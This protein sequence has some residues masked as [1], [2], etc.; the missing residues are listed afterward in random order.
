MRYDTTKQL[1][2]PVL[3]LAFN[4]PKKTK[5][6]FDSIRSVKPV[7]LYVAVDGPR[8]GREDDIINSNQVKEIVKDVDWSCDVHYL[9]HD[10]NLGCS[11]SGYMAWKWIMETEDRMI[12][13][14][15]DGLGS[16]EAF[17]FI[18]DMLERYNDDERVS[19]V[20]AVNYGPK[21]GEASYFYSRIP[22]ATYFM[23]TWKR[24]MDRYEYLLD[25]FPIIRK[26]PD[27]RSAF[28]CW[29]ERLVFMQQFKSYRH[30]VAKGPKQNTYDT[31]M[32]YLSFKYKTFSIYPNV[33][34]VSNIGLDGG[35]NNSCSTDSDFY[36]EYGN[37]KIETLGDIIY[38]D[39]VGYNEDFEISFFNKR[40]LYLKPWYR[41]VLKSFL[42]QHLGKFYNKWIRK[43]RRK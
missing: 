13:V 24:V 19:Y 30:S 17:F 20:G 29:H 15:D 22:S 32:N 8:V 37:R 23:G 10:E 25:S 38:N 43:Y 33:N 34:L 7:R 41:V 1:T 6:V 5:Q 27:F 35:A 42:Y 31:Q 36:K 4:R 12:F 40:I 16:P 39:K 28:V 2:T 9:F 3:F 14:E 11:K 26:S 21:F 18:Q